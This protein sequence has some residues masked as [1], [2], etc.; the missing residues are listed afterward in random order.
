MSTFVQE[1]HRTTKQI[2]ELLVWSPDR[3]PGLPQFST[4][5]EKIEWTNPPHV[6]LWRADHACDGDV[7]PA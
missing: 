3:S 2:P 6:V 4:S 1:F 5:F 7:C